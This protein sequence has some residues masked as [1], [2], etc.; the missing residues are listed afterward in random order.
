VTADRTYG[1]SKADA[2]ALVASIGTTE[3]EIPQLFPGG[4]GGGADI[5]EY[6]IVSLST[7]SSGP[8]NGLRV[9]SATVK[10]AG[11]SRASLI[12]TV[13]DVVDHS[14]GIFDAGGTMAGYTGWAYEAQYISRAAGAECD[15]L[16]PCHW[17]AIN[18]VCAPNTGDYADPCEE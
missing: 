12:G 2:E 15:D 17:A 11:C 18:R 10:G 4:G 16:S 5:I 3:T 14:G 9:A 1:F 7:P 6:K 13:V 8:Y